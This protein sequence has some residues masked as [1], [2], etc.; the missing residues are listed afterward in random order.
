MDVCYH[1]T[2]PEDREEVR[3]GSGEETQMGRSHSV[4][5]NTDMHADKI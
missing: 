4:H 1:K 5:T 2:V 3:G